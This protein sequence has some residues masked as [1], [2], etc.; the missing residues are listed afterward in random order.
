MPVKKKVRQILFR[1]RATP[2]SRGKTLAELY[3]HWK[4]RIVS[5]PSSQK[6]RNQQPTPRPL[7]VR[8]QR[9]R[10]Y[11]CESMK[12]I[13]I[14]WISEPSNVNLAHVTTS[15]GWT[16]VGRQ[17]S[18]SINFEVL[19]VEDKDQIESHIAAAPPPAM[20]TFISRTVI[21]KEKRKCSGP[22]GMSTWQ[23]TKTI[24]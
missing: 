14:F 5:T 4:M 24:Y 17:K 21:P 23:C 15:F 8:F 16:P 20:A 7:V 2:L 1:Y 9:G 3:L 11:K 12:I 6:K 10:E 19:W 18:T 13:E 22:T